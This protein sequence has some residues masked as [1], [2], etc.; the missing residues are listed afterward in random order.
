M[1]AEYQRTTK[2]VEVYSKRHGEVS[3]I[4]IVG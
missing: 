1:S 4:E 3:L 2:K